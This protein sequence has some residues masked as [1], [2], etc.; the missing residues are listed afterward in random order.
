MEMSPAHH[1]SLRMA[2][3]AVLTTFAA[4]AQASFILMQIDAPRRTPPESLSAVNGVDPTVLGGSLAII[5]EGAGD[6]MAVHFFAAEAV[7]LHEVT[8]GDSQIDNGG[9]LGW[10]QRSLGNLGATDGTI[11]FRFCA[12]TMGECLT[13]AQNDASRLGSLQSLGMWLSANRD[14]AWLLRDDSGTVPDANHD[15]PIVRLSY[16]SVP[17]PGTLALLGLGLLG[18]DFA[19]RKT[20]DAGNRDPMSGR[21][22]A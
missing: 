12:V 20:A 11:N 17:E 19:R 16:W 22:Q 18:V 5:D 7:Y 8:I 6:S 10:S 13:H 21:V 3:F 1:R 14:T 15:G 2:A 9:N 4:T